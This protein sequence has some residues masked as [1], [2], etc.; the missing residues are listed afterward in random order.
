[1]T[2]LR[3][4]GQSGVT[5]I[6]LL[7][8]MVIIAM[9]GAPLAG[10]IFLSFRSEVGAGNRNDAAKQIGLL[11]ANLQRD[12]GE[13]EV[14]D[15][16]PTEAEILK[17]DGGPADNN[18][19]RLLTVQSPLEVDTSVSPPVTIRMQV[20]YN[21]SRAV[22]Q[23]GNVIPD[24]Y[25]I[26]RQACDATTRALV[27]QPS[28]LVHSVEVPPLPIDE[29]NAATDPARCIGGTGD[30][31]DNQCPVVQMRV[32]PLAEGAITA[33]VTASSRVVTS[34]GDGQ[35]F[36][37]GDIPVTIKATRTDG[38]PLTGDESEGTQVLLSAE[39]TY[40]NPVTYSWTMPPGATPKTPGWTPASTSGKFQF[41]SAGRYPIFLYIFDTGNPEHYGTASLSIVIGNKAPIVRVSCGSS[42][43]V[44][45]GAQPCNL[46]RG[47][48]SLSA[49]DSSDP[50]GS[51]LTYAW[52]SLDGGG[53]NYDPSV[54]VRQTYSG[55]AVIP[56]GSVD[57]LVCDPLP[58]RN[59][60]GCGPSAQVLFNAPGSR[61][62]KVTVTDADGMATSLLVPI[63]VVTQPPMVT[64]TNTTTPRVPPGGGT[65]TFKAVANLPS[66]YGPNDKY[67]WARMITWE[68]VDANDVTVQTFT[69]DLGAEPLWTSYVA[70]SLARGPSPGRSP[71]TARS[72]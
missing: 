24:E 8:G 72:R 65:V 7:L 62:V 13:A 38:T 4:R 31:V 61:T 49:S 6:E 69:D 58:P 59:D 52:Q 57:R 30:F 9:L 70:Q 50:E 18:A 48:R 16:S 43:Y 60:T 34:S 51:P 29:G 45:E 67:P 27:G 55:G 12:V 35:A 33:S 17:C 37:L 2:A 3:P 66:P 40:A 46:M 47:S 39:F 23:S 36:D 56:E 10:L 68:V 11:K 71:S 25:S 28:Q 54:H 21:F 22:D 44:D 32:T 41:D 19:T 15:T 14:I 63:F 20:D 53:S 26:W 1:M 64:L 5:V 42:V